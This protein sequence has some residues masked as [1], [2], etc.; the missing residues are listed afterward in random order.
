MLTS[1]TKP[2]A[3]LPRT[4]APAL[5]WFR[6]DLRVRDNPALSAAAGSGRRVACLYLHDE[7]SPG[8]R[9][10]GGGARWWLAGSLAAL[11]DALAERGARLVLRRGEAATAVPAFAAEIGASAVLFNRRYDPAGMAADRAAEAELA[12]RGI[13]V[14]SFQAGLLY[15]PG[16]VVGRAGQP[17]RTFASFARAART[18]G[19]PRPPLK[20]PSHFTAAMRGTGERLEDWQLEP[21]APDWAG[22]LRET[23][24]RGEA[25]A[26][27]R[28][29]AF[30]EEG[31]AGYAV[32]RDRPDLEA[33]ARL[34]PSLRFGELSPFQ[35]WHAVRHACEASPGRQLGA[36]KFLS[37]LEWREFCWHLLFHFPGLPQHNLQPR[38]D[39][40]PWRRD[41]AALVAWE[42]G[43]TGYPIVD[44]GMRQLWRTGWMHN[45]VRMVVASFLT[46]HL[47]VDWRDGEA[48]FW[49]TLVDADA[50]NNPAN[51]QWV[52]GCGVDAAPY[53]RIF[54]PV[55][56]GRKFDPLGAYVR[57]YVPEIATLP[58]E[59]IHEPWLAPAAILDQAG[60]APGE[61]YPRPIV[62]H[63]TARRRALAAF[64]TT[65]R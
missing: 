25:A 8:V 35:V 63:A 47:L 19:D 28:L 16:T 49:D 50:A 46:K 10:L 48:W 39:A 15:E 43:Q 6:D 61:T 30:I 56:Q 22:G 32:A 51:W 54:N 2:G 37:E 44:A 23:W 40:F 58:D 18:Q 4:D 52:A 59:L 62:D 11:G 9:R 41:G 27:A 21:H 33:T 57:R 36:G 42:R 17:L 34:S 38:F 45:R 65:K 55:L 31:L 60:I 24:T 26:H 20:M 12:A 14:E 3:L 13:T 5:M 7:N 64:A 53:F 1:P 29:A